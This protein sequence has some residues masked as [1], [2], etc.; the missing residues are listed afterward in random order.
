[1]QALSIYDIAQI[2]KKS[3]LRI[4]AFA[5][6]IGILAFIAASSLQTYTCT[7]GFK[8]NHEG[9]AENLAPDGESKLDPYEIQNPVVIQAALNGIGID[10]KG[11]SEKHRRLPYRLYKRPNQR[12]NT[13]KSAPFSPICGC[14]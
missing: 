2:I 4:T 5:L 1:M 7:L 12:G 9:A 3:F 6:I 10:N 13:R 11:K 8:Y 14:Y